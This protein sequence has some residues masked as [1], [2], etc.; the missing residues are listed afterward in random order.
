MDVVVEDHPEEERYVALVDGKPGG[1]I[2]YH[3]RSGL[4]ALVHTEVDE[5][6]E[7]KGVGAALVSGALE[8]IRGKGLDLL[9]FCP[10]VNRYIQEHPEYVDLVPETRR[11]AFGL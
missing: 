2:A 5:Q 8:D 4:I 11:E 7:G 3:G 10:F 9:P 1:F 6:L